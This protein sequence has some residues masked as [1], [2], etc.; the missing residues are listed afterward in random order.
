M[1]GVSLI[2]LGWSGERRLEIG[3]IMWL[4]DSSFIVVNEE[5]NKTQKKKKR[6]LISTF[7]DRRNIAA[8]EA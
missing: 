5:C 8:R 4:E 6:K 7:Y 3:L 2:T 1:S